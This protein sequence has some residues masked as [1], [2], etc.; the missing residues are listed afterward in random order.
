MPNEPW[1]T[2]RRRGRPRVVAPMV[3]TSVRLPATLF[4]AY[5]QKAVREGDSLPEV[6]RRV[7][8]RSIQAPP[9]RRDF[10]S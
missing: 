7:L 8:E 4:D 1:I 2:P 6:I 9:A 10:S 5:C 3:R